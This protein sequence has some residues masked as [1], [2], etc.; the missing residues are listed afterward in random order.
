[1]SLKWVSYGTHLK[2]SAPDGWFSADYQPSKHDADI[3]R[4]VPYDTHFKDMNNLHDEIFRKF[5]Q[6][7][8]LHPGVDYSHRQNQQY[9]E[10][11]ILLSNLDRFFEYADLCISTNGFFNEPENPVFKKCR[12]FIDVNG[13]TLKKELLNKAEIAN[14]C[15]QILTGLDELKQSQM[16]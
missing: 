4:W 6:K 14:V 9:T 2:I 1:M 10:N 16:Q 11:N 12:Y 13:N 7:V 5:G 15:D 8:F 3:L